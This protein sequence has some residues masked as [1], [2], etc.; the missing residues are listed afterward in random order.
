MPA[1]SL[2]EVGVCGSSRRT[3]LL[4]YC[5]LLSVVCG[6][7]GGGGRSL[8]TGLPLL[9]FHRYMMAASVGC[10]SVLSRQAMVS[11]AVQLRTVDIKGSIFTLRHPRYCDLCF[12]AISHVVN[13]QHF[14]TFLRH[15][16][17][18]SVVTRTATAND[19]YPHPLAH[20]HDGIVMRAVCGF[21]LVRLRTSGSTLRYPAGRPIHGFRD[22]CS[23]WVARN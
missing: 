1:S 8:I 5:A 14:L 21:R 10:A 11:E 17:T 18:M 19:E 9:S 23:G 15:L 20:P 13:A 16:F 6:V 12:S 7:P 4:P 3:P 22:R 2:F